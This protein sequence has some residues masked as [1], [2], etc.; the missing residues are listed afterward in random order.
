MKLLRV[1]P[2]IAALCGAAAL[3]LATSA[4]GGGSSSAAGAGSGAGSHAATGSPIILFSINILSGPEA[5]EPEI[6]VATEAAVNAI[7]AAG[8]I[9][10]RP[11]KVINCDEG[12]G[13]NASEACAREA[14]QDKALALVGDSSAFGD[15]DVPIVT[16][17]GIPLIGP[18]PNST[19]EL[20]NPLSFP[21]TSNS[22]TT[23]T[24]AI[25]MEKLGCQHIK[26]MAA[27]VPV[28]QYTLQ[29]GF[30]APLKKAGGNID[31]VVAPPLTATDLSPYISQ[32]GAGADC[33]TPLTSGD[34]A[35]IVAQGLAQDNYA[36]KFFFGTLQWGQKEISELGSAAANTYLAGGEAVATDSAVPG[37]A[38]FNKQMDAT[39]NTSV[40]RDMLAVN[41]WMSIHVVAQLA[42]TLTV[43]N[44]G[45]LVAAL[46]AKPISYEGI[47][48]PV[49]F[50]KPNTTFAPSPLITYNTLQKVYK[51]TDGK[52]VPLFGG[53]FV[54]A[55]DPTSW[56]TP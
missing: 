39:G 8:G 44:S 4:C 32:L 25:L 2:G 49:D 56:P 31:A 48:A 52:L 16:A 20:S 23:A 38:A 33:V 50:S 3:A 35:L 43:V 6:P 36:G 9:K 17:A 7:N 34:Q 29:S 26:V 11:V 1:R 41:M 55:A 14:V 24:E 18:I 47:T 22:V 40:S 19:A 37:I 28:V 13:Q 51:V 27:D 30:V 53:K 15:T 5:T 12:T 42:S 54:D 46:K 21:F 45:N 10:G